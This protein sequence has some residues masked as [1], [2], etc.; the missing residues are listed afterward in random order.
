MPFYWWARIFFLVLVTFIAVKLRAPCSS[1]AFTPLGVQPCKCRPFLHFLR[2]ICAASASLRHSPR[3]KPCNSSH[4]IVR[5]AAVRA[6]SLHLVILL[7]LF[8]AASA[9]L[10][11]ASSLSKKLKKQVCAPL[12]VA[13]A[14]RLASAGALHMGRGGAPPLHVPPTYCPC[15]QAAAVCHSCNINA[16]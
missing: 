15:R 7:S 10:R 6:S 3:R 13:S 8:C 2:F 9:S 12:A 16:F 11:L 14:Y 5:A 1:A 4:F